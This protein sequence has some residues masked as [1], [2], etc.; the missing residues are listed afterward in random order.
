MS[1]DNGLGAVVSKNNQLDTMPAVD[2]L[3]A[4]KHG[5]G[6]DWW[7]LYKQW[8]PG[9]NYFYK[10]LIT[11]DGVQLNSVDTV[12]LF[13]TSN[14]GDLVFNSDGSRFAFCNW[15]GLLALYNFDRCTGQIT[16]SDTIEKEDQNGNY[17]YYFSCA[18]S[19]NDSILYV[20]SAPYYTSLDVND[21]YLSQ[22]NLTAL[23]IAASLKI[24]YQFQYPVFP[25][26]LRLAPDNK[27]YVASD[28]NLY[29]Y[30]SSDYYTSNTYL[31]VINEPNKL[32]T[33]CN[34]QPFSFYLGGKRTYWGLPNNPN[35]DL[36][37][38]LQ[39]VCDSLFNSV[40]QISKGQT[41]ITIYP[42]PTTGIITLNRI[43]F[44]YSKC[45]F[46]VFDLDG[47]QCYSSVLDVT[48]NPIQKDLSILKNGIY[49]L[50]IQRDGKI[51]ET[52][53]LIIIK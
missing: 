2:C 27:I 14:G 51:I 38:V 4:I 47:K 3:Q 10:Y 39:S 33:A 24:I 19:K 50:R 17:P 15:R 53:K 44:G 37:P 8:Q 11:P 46:D 6:R 35:Y 23:N 32:D 7:L 42:N 1:Q 41:G 13:S 43:F 16:V 12:G 5:N 31:S 40:E 18:F 36:G 21:I 52:M 30:D 34:F 28:P 48:I 22:Y 29:P 49:F 20:S 26:A 9:N 25:G 45:T